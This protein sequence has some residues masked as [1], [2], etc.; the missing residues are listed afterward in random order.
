MEYFGEQQTDFLRPTK[1][2]RAYVTESR[3]CWFQSR[4][5]VKKDGQQCWWL[6]QLLQTMIVK[7]WRISKRRL[8]DVTNLRLFYGFVFYLLVNTIRQVSRTFDLRCPMERG[9]FRV[10]TLP[11]RVYRISCSRASVGKK[12]FTWLTSIPHNSYR[13]R[14]I[15]MLPE[16][17]DSGWKRHNEH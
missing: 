3:N 5:E 7:F 4:G 17:G 12:R 15:R 10:S 11:R 14:M 2:R 8:R 6:N 16:L 1:N 9:L 13:S